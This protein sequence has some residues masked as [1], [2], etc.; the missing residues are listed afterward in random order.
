MDQAIMKA[1]E[2]GYRIPNSKV[3]FHPDAETQ[4]VNVR[5]T[6][7][8]WEVLCDPSFWSSLGKAMDAKKGWRNGM[9]ARYYAD[10]AGGIDW[11]LDLEH[12]VDMSAWQYQWHL[13]IEHLAEGKDADSFFKELLP[14]N[15]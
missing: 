11:E 13:F 5:V 4:S 14:T 7:N 9:A 15:A 8:K 1:A 12:E 2:A 3:D 10:R 6:M